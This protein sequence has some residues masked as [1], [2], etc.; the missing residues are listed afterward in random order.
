MVSVMRVKLLAACLG[1]LLWATACERD[2]PLPE[3]DTTYYPIVPGKYRTYFIHDT[4]FVTGSGPLGVTAVDSVYF[5]R[6]TTTD[7]VIDLLGRTA[8]WLEL[9]IAPGD[10]A[11]GQPGEFR[12]LELWT[13]WMDQRF[14]ERT[15]GNLRYQVLA[16]PAYKG[17][18]WNGNEWNAQN[19][20]QQT[21]DLNLQYTATSFFFLSTDTAITLPNGRRYEHC[22]V[23][24]WRESDPNSI[25]Y[26]ALTWEVYAPGIGL[27]YR[28]DRYKKIDQQGAETRLDTRSYVR[29][30]YLWEHNY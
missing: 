14:A 30:Q 19:N 7:T 25:F 12:Y 22:W 1:S 23:A 17:R 27:I 5:R 8:W 3:L 28:Y 29:E 21:S 20:N 24:Q 16:F 10:S 9:E 4:T 26:D 13:Q 18:A 11:T 6:E 2:L 15:E